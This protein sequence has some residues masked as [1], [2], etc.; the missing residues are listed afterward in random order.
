M[1]AADFYPRE[2]FTRW[3][4]NKSIEDHF[5][6][7]YVLFTDETTFTRS[8]VFNTHN[9]HM[10]RNENPHVVHQN[11]HQQRFSVNVLLAGIVG[12]NLVGP[13]LLSTR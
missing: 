12:N 9:L 4:I 1:L 10:W 2:Q 6:P 8:G 11:R 13:Y 7:K 5:F 3:F